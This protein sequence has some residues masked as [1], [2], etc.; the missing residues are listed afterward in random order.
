MHQSIL[1][2]RRV[3]VLAREHSSTDLLPLGSAIIV[4]DVGI[5]GL[6]YSGKSTLFTAL[7]RTGFAGGR[8][9][10]AVVDVP[11]Q[12]VHALARLEGSRKVTPAKVRFADAPGGVSARAIGEHRQTDALCVVLDAF[13]PGADPTGDLDALR[14]EL[15]VADLQSI[16]SGLTKARKR[17]R[18]TPE[19]GGEVA[20]LEAA[21]EALSS[22]RAVRDAGLDEGSTRVL[23]GYGLLTMKPWIVVRNVSEELLEG[24]AEG[25][26]ADALTIDA[27]LEAEV[28]GMDAGE[29]AELLAGFGISEPGLDRIIRACYAAL[30]IVTFLTTNPDEARAWQVHRGATAPVAAGVIHSDLE[31]G[32]IRAEVVS[33]DD[34]SSAGGWDDA[35]ARGLVRTEGRSY[36]VSEGDVMKVRFAV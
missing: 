8:S 29:A 9:N 31:R 24:A 36:V 32:F 27:A 34:L 28:A 4:R 2:V 6:P 33:F 18:A 26:L 7:T 12:R 17:A 21:H 22:D 14:T 13:R 16:E 10:Q 11:D 23:R 1:V 5:I 19:D 15:L 35:R 3:S 30:D 20:A 25:D